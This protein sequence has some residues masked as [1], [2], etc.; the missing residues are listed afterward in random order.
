[1]R[2]ISDFNDYY[3][4]V[5]RQGQD[6]LIYVRKQQTFEYPARVYAGRNRVGAENKFPRKLLYYNGVGEYLDIRGVWV[7]FCGKIYPVV[8]ICGGNKVYKGSKYYFPRKVCFSPDEVNEAI[9][10]LPIPDKA[11]VRYN[12][13]RIYHHQLGIRCKMDTHIFFTETERLNAKYEYLFYEYNAPV[14][15]A[16]YCWSRPDYFSVLT[17]CRLADMQF[18]RRFDSYSAFQEINMYLS[19][20]L[21]D[22]TEKI[23]NVSDKDMINA[24]GFDKFSFRKDKKKKK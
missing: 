5:Q 9:D 17:N 15:L 23:P 4:G 13:K 7:G 10:E 2:I 24:K 14:F 21:G 1:M 19:G 11:K 16:K 12:A 18:Y 8:S 20:V 22:T 3:D 6:D